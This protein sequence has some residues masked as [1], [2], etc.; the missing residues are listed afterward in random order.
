MNEDAVIQLIQEALKTTALVSAPLLLATLAI[1]V[2]I[3]ILQALTQIN[4][5]SLNF[6]PKIVVVAVV[7]IV[8]GPWMMDVMSHYTTNLY[9]NINIM[10]RE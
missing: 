7:I 8:A 6:I 2:I 4:E 5:A 3:S 10:V 1:G 9:E